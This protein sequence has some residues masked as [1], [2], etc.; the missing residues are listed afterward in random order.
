MKA[1]SI[2]SFVEYKIEH[3]RESEVGARM[4][5]KLRK[6]EKILDEKYEKINRKNK[7]IKSCKFDS[8]K[9]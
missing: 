1:K 4:F 6:Y 5:T 7:E 8:K 2:E 9:L 3:H